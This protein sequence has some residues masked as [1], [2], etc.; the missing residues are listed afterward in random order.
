MLINA[1]QTTLAF[2]PAPED[3]DEVFFDAPV[4]AFAPTQ[5]DDEESEQGEP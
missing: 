1:L 4:I 5:R 3:L 2:S